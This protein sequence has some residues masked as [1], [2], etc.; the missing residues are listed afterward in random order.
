ML[1]AL[2]S[3]IPDNNLIRLDLISRGVEKRTSCIIR[4]LP[5]KMTQLELMEVQ[6]LSLC[7]DQRA[8]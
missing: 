1:D 3:P 5:N 4:N 2:D 8:D 6:R 7:Y